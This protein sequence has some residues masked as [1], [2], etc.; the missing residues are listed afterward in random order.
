LDAAFMTMN[1]LRERYVGG[2][3]AVDLTRVDG[4]YGFIAEIAKRSSDW[5][6]GLLTTVPSGR[7][8]D[9]LPYVAPE[10]VQYLRIASRNSAD[11]SEPESNLAESMRKVIDA[12]MKIDWLCYVDANQSY[13]ERACDL[14]RS[15]REESKKK[16]GKL[17]FIPVS[18]GKSE[19]P[20][21]SI[22]VNGDCL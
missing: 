3:L 11:L 12:G 21:T 16:R 6:Y 19:Q 17:N 5:S 14:A 13:L 10:G 15:L 7:V 2:V 4:D 9:I 20:D 22:R 1:Q 8:A 18:D